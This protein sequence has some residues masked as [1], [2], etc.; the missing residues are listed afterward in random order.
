MKKNKKYAT[1]RVKALRTPAKLSDYFFHFEKLEPMPLG[2]YVRESSRSQKNN[3][4]FQR[5]N[6]EANVVKPDFSVFGVYEEII[7]GWAEERRGFECAVLEAFTVGGAVVA[8]CVNRLIRHRRKLDTFFTVFEMKELMSQVAGVPL[9]TIL[10]PDSPPDEVSSYQ[11]KRGQAGNGNYGG[12]PKKIHHSK[13]LIRLENKDE[14]I[15]L[16]N[17]GLSYRKIGRWLNIH[18][19]TIRDWIKSEEKPH[20]SFP[21]ST[22][23]RNAGK[24]GEI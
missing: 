16:R 18:W 2:L 7:P 1:E 8:E 15:E 23:A 19:S 5:T 13:K 3:L 14:A 21:N 22:I 6:L 17:D 11:T 9:A 24:T 10:H 4:P 20:T 12:R